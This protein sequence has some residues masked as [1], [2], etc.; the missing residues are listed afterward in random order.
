VRQGRTFD[1]LSREGA[2]V[3]N[4]LL[5]SVILGIVLIGTLYPL[6]V[7]AVTGE[8]LSVG[9]PYFMAAAAPLALLLVAVMAAG[10]LLR[11]RRAQGRALLRRLVIP[12]IVAGAALLLVLLL[13]PPLPILPLLGLIF[14]AGAAA[15]S[16]APLWKRKLRRAPLFLWGM[17]IAHLGISV[18]LAGMASESAF[19]KERLVALAP[20]QSTIVGPWTV[21]F[22]AVEPVA[23]PNWT[24]M[25][26]RLTAR[27]HGRAPILLEPQARS[28]SAPPTQT[29][30]AAIS[31]RADG[32]IYAVIGKP[33][34]GGRWQLRLWWKPFVT[35]IWLG[36]AMVAFGGMISLV[37][38][39]R[40]ERAGEGRAA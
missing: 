34:E 15:A 36:G 25:Q 7:E 32:Q 1:F 12:L 38:R 3:V 2:L 9:P 16:V 28:F 20:G 4:N 37:G 24:A 17:V 13:A 26:A 35:L 19:S 11:W 10:P 30:E 29:S 6:L 31:T 23:G 33:G 22:Q 27:R 21:Q 8:K 40:R 5:F 39:L 14:A 18:S